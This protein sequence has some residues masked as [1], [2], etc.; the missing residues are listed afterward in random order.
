MNS[1][2]MIN[3]WIKKKLKEKDDKYEELL[4]LTSGLFSKIKDNEE[5]INSLDDKSKEVLEQVKSK[6]LM[7]EKRKKK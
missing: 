6:L 4:I 7:I 5:M 2:F 1:L 3:K